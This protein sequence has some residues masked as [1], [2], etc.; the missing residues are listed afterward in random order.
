MLDQGATGL[1]QRCRR[2]IDLSLAEQGSVSPAILAKGLPFFAMRVTEKGQECESGRIP[3]TDL[4]PE[5]EEKT[6]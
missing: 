6:G 5:R 4:K 2:F 3:S 1:H